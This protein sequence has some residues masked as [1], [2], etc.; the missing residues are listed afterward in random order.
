MKNLVK[1][2]RVRYVSDVSFEVGEVTSTVYVPHGSGKNEALLVPAV[3]IKG[4]R[5]AI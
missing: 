4:S 1:D 3:L 5:Y 2:T